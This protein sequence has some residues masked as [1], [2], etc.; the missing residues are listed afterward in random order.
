MPKRPR[1]SFCLSKTNGIKVRLFS[2]T[3]T[4]ASRS[5]LFDYT[6]GRW[7]YNDALRHRERRRIF[8]V[9]EL[10]RL[11]AS[12]IG[13]KEEDVVGFEK[14]AEGG[15][16][17]TFLVTMRDTFRFVARIPYPVTQPKSL[18]IASEVAT[19]DYLRAHDIP[20]PQVYGYS[21]TADNPAETEYIFMELMPGHNLGD[22]WFDLTE[23]QR[24]RLLTQ[25]VQVESRLFALRFPASGSLYY[26]SDL[27]EHTKVIVAS[28]TTSAGRFCIGPETSLGLVY[29]RRSSLQVDRGPYQDTLT[30]L[31]AG[32]KKEIAYLSQFGQP[33]QPFQRLR[34]ETYNYQPQSH[35]DHIATL[36]QYLQIAPSLTPHNNPA[37]QRP[38]LRHPDLQPNNIFVTNELEITALI[39]W[40]H[41]AILPLFLQCAIPNSIQNYGDEISES[42]TEPTV[43]ANFNDLEPQEQ[44][45]QADLFRKRQLHY[46]YVKMTSQMNTEHYDALAHGFST[47]RRRIFHHAS[48]PWE[49]DNVSLKSDLITLSQ[50]WTNIN[51]TGGNAP[52]CPLVYS[53]AEST[54]CFRLARAQAEADEQFRLCRDVIGAGNEGWVHVDQYEEVKARERTLRR[55]ALDAAETDQ[56]RKEIEENWI[57]DDFDEDGY[58]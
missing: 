1:L 4:K 3:H 28:P 26:C 14:L 55:N 21:A 30:A 8:N 10:K 35:L 38:V 45:A 47:L 41:T 42:L 27:P 34:R 12:S 16:N 37:L 13:Q 22:I 19:M 43:P 40:Q 2:T 7:I 51:G 25:L 49:G 39:D 46:L 9:P 17:R 54:E 44:Y 32:A 53:D 23:K 58:M 50:K 15:F 6:S 18:V 36:N 11:A 33:L 24:S 56:E 20:V 31:T 29:G 52:P 48:E 5:D 57:F